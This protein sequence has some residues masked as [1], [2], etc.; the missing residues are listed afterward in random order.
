MSDSAE[1]MRRKRRKDQVIAEARANAFPAPR[2][3]SDGE[4]GMRLATRAER[5]QMYL[6]NQDRAEAYARWRIAAYESGECASPY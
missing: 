6:A 2:E 1:R 3:I 4:G 5:E